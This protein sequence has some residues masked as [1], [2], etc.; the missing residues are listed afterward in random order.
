MRLAD[1]VAFE[2]MLEVLLGV[3]ESSTASR[4][5]ET[6]PPRASP[7]QGI[8]FHACHSVVSWITTG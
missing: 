4:G 3:C 2:N 8:S 6:V 5:A 7:T 1:V